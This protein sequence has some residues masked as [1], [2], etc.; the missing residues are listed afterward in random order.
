LFC[1][2][3]DW[4]CVLFLY[5][6]ATKKAESVTSRPYLYVTAT[7]LLPISV[8]YPHPIIL[9]VSTWRMPRIGSKGNNFLCGILLQPHLNLLGDLLWF[10]GGCLG[11]GKKCPARNLLLDLHVHNMLPRSFRSNIGSQNKRS[12]HHHEYASNELFHG[13]ISFVRQKHEPLS[14]VFI[15]PYYMYTCQVHPLK[16]SFAKATEG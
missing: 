2:I 9:V 13:A 4:L 16:P 11:I 1:L 14:N 6:Y 3:F 10:G 12:S 15:I 8:D 7:S 5:F